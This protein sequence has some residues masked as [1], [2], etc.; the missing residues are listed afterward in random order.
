M[1][2]NPRAQR[3]KGDQI[4][5]LLVVMLLISGGLYLWYRSSASRSTAERG[6]S[7]ATHST[8]TKTDNGLAE[9]EIE[10][11]R[12]RLAKPRATSI[13]K[14]ISD[15]VPDNAGATDSPGTAG[16]GPGKSASKMQDRLPQ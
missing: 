16:T 6:P 11:A 7:S 12:R 13:A 8:F 14:E 10:L 1:T 15:R 2:D 4:R 9:E 5:L 3:E